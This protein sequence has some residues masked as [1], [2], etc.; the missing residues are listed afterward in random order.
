[1][2]KEA[3][4]TY[5]CSLRFRSTGYTKVLIN[6]HK[7]WRCVDF[8]GVEDQK[9]VAELLG[10]PATASRKARRGASCSSPSSVRQVMDENTPEDRESRPQEGGKEECS[11]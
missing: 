10:I 7:R 11:G 2:P 9:R 8:S 5:Y 6:V 3:P 4:A 1:M